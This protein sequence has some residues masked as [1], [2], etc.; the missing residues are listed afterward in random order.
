[1]TEEQKQYIID[2]H[3]YQT[4]YELADN[5][6]IKPCTL[7]VH[8]SKNNIEPITAGT[9]A[10][11]YLKSH[12]G[13]TIKQICKRLD[14][15]IASA[16]AYCAKLKYMIISEQVTVRPLPSKKTPPAMQLSPEAH[17]YINRFLDKL[18]AKILGEDT[19]KRSRPPAVY[20][21]IP[22]DYYK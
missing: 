10:L 18:E 12:P 22:N 20:T 3:Q 7:S 2:N 15:S 11:E 1:M 21:N 17:Y 5:L 13:L 9:R 8:C 19:P 6:Q 16:K 14:I 4:L